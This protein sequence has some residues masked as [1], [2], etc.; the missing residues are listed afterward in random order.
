[1][2]VRDPGLWL[3]EIDGDLGF[4]RNRECDRTISLLSLGMISSYQS[5]DFN[6]ISFDIP[7][8]SGLSDEIS[9]KFW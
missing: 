8:F 3:L 7:Y 6:E 4:N 2:W 5:W 9:G 1:M